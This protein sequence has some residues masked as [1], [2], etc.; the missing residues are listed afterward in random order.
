MQRTATARPP[1]IWQREWCAHLQG[2]RGCIARAVHTL[3]LH[4]LLYR[5]LT[6]EAV[7][8][9]ASCFVPWCH[10]CCVVVGFTSAVLLPLPLLLLLLLLL[11]C[12]SAD[13]R[14]PLNQAPEVMEKLRAATYA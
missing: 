7:F 4:L 11:C 12:C 5:Q 13:E 6:A 1:W 10:I 8:R 14:N 2:C 3:K 9:G